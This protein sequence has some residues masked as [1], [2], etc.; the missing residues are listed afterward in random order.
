MKIKNSSTCLSRKVLERNVVLNQ[1]CESDMTVLKKRIDFA[2]QIV[3]VSV[4]DR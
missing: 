1:Y 4:M 2:V 3:I